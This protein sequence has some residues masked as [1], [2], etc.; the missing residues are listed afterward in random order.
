MDFHE[1]F[2]A[3]R[4]IHVNEVYVQNFTI[5]KG[6]SRRRMTCSTTLLAH[7]LGTGTPH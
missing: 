1:T 4:L 3:A 6:A 2:F 5:A 7:A